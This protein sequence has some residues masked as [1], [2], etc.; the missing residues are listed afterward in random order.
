LI[1]TLSAILVSGVVGAAA[2]ATYYQ[3]VPVHAA[4]VAPVDLS[5]VT[6]ALNRLAEQQ[7]AQGQALGEVN[8]TLKEQQA[9]VLLV[10]Q[11]LLRQE[12]AQDA[13]RAQTQA[14]VNRLNSDFSNFQKAMPR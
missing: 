3:V 4:A 1:K 8:T 13:A 5:G 6:Q 10:H 7:Q 14:R 9:G 12:A 11:D 2:T